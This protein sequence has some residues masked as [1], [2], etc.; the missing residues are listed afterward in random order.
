MRINMI[1]AKE[2]LSL[3]QFS[4]LEIKKNKN[5]KQQ[6]LRCLKFMLDKSELRSWSRYGILFTWLDKSRGFI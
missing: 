3:I 1:E 4:Y 2:T 6:V 5:R